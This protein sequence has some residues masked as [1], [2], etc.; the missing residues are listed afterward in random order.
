MQCKKSWSMG[1]ILHIHILI[2]DSQGRGFLFATTQSYTERQY[3]VMTMK[4]S[5]LGNRWFERS[6]YPRI[7]V[8]E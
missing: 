4:A 1:V 6:E 7:G 5:P 3:T 8:R 2:L